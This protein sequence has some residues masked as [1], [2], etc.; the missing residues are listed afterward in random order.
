LALLIPR[1]HGAYGQ[2]LMPLVVALV[3]GGAAA[4]ALALAAAAVAVFLAHEPLLVLLGQRGGRASRDQN[5]DARRSLVLFGIVAIVS[6][7]LAVALLPT[8][9]RLALVVPVALVL[10]AAVLVTSGRERTTGGEV[11]I[12]F[13]LTSASF[14]VAM[15]GGVSVQ[16]AATVGAVFAA[17]FV[18]ATLA[19]RAVIA[20][21]TGSPH[22]PNRAAA[23]I[24]VV[25]LVLALGIL[26]GYG[27]VARVAMW[28]AAPACLLALVLLASMPA[29]RHLRR[30]G[31]TIVGVTAVAGVVLM[32]ALR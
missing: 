21:A 32:A 23:A 26:T 7:C 1:E 15:A 31:W 5:A 29:P 30:I 25:L 20:R 8:R 4:G 24:V 10:A 19:V 9:G 12:A 18:S 14:P 6:G 11:L 16:A 2:L 13:T 22:G 27:V 3:I 17:A 28:A